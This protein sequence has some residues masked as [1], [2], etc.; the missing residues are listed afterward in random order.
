M[1]VLVKHDIGCKWGRFEG[2]VD[3]SARILAGGMKPGHSDAAKRFADMYNLHKAAGQV[4]GWIAVK[5]LDGSSNG[6]VY[7]SRPEAVADLF[8]REDEY[9]YATLTQPPMSVCQ[10]ESLLRYKRVMSEM[11]RAHADRDAPHGGREVIPRL[12]VEDQE[13]Q[14]AAV[15]SGTGYVPMG[16]RRG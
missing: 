7:D 10:A 13:A 16:Y 2:T 3:A 14:I 9:F 12:A 6:T 11:D 4:R 15:R 8:P 5:Y 1:T